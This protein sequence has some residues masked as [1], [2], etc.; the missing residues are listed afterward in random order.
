MSVTKKAAEAGAT[1]AQTL[2][3][4]QDNIDTITDPKQLVQEVLKWDAVKQ[5]S[6]IFSYHVRPPPLFH[7]SPFDR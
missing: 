7:S 3:Q 6:E 1:V 5:N 4:I 2:A